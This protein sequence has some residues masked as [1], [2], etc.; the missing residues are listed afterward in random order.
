[1]IDFDAIVNTAVETAFAEKVNPIYRPIVSDPGVPSFEIKGIFDRHH[2]V[3]LDEI[4]R[5]ESRGAGHSTTAPV[6]SVRLAQFAVPPL[7]DDEVTIKSEDFMVY[8]VQ[9]DGRGMADLVL[10]EKV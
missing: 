4:A 6:L 5:S 9:P 1:M 2:E 7:Q 8:D 3:V 10:R